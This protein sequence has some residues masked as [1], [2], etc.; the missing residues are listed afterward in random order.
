MDHNRS[1]PC[2]KDTYILPYLKLALFQA[3]KYPTASSSVRNI[4]RNIQ[5]IVGGN[6]LDIIAPVVSLLFLPI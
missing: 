2:P 1:L 4:K 6:T 5:C 3:L